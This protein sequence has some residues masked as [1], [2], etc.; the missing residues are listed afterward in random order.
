MTEAGSEFQVV[1]ATQLND[2]LLMAARLKGTWSSGTSDDLSDRVPL[3]AV[4]CRLR[5]ACA[6][7]CRIL[8]VSKASL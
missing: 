6:D 1:G 2:R 4:M 5:Y 8:N 7:V 3:R